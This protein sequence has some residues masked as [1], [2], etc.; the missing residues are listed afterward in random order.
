MKN[1]N[2]WL[3]ILAFFLGTVAGNFTKQ[4]TIY[5]LAGNIYF[6]AEDCSEYTQISDGNVSTSWSVVDSSSTFYIAN[7]KHNNE[8][9]AHMLSK[10]KVIP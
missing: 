10:F 4:P 2:L 7:W 3:I 8:G 5:K 9:C 6:N 1:I